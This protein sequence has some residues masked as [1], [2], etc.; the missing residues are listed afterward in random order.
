MPKTASA[1][2]KKRPTVTVYCVAQRY[3]GPEERIIEFSFPDGSGGLIK[4]GSAHPE[5]RPN[6]IDVY[7]V[8]KGVVLTCGEVDRP[9]DVQR[10]GA[11]GHTVKVTL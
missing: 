9:P 2:R 6:H 7:R 5:G 10:V 4:F 11:Y 1:Y 3:A 8:D